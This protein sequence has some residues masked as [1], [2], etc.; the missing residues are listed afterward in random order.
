VDPISYAHLLDKSKVTFIDAY[1]DRTLPV[2][3]RKLLYDE[4]EGANR[5]VLPISHVSWLPFGYFLAKYMLY[6]LNINEKEIKKALL[7]R[8]IME[9]PLEK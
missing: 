7:T 8:E 5:K 6:K 9:N 2:E 4:M 3:S 1:F